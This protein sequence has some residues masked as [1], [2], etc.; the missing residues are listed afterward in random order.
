MSMTG[1][2]TCSCLVSAD[3]NFGKSRKSS[4][5]MILQYAA[6]HKAICCWHAQFTT[7]SQQTAAL[8]TAQPVFPGAAQCLLQGNR[9]EDPSQSAASFKQQLQQRYGDNCPEFRETSWQDAAAE[10]HQQYKFLLVYLHSPDHE[11]KL[12]FLL[13][14][15]INCPALHVYCFSLPLQEPVFLQSSC[16]VCIDMPVSVSVCA[17][18]CVCIG[19]SVRAFAILQ[20]HLSI[21]FLEGMTRIILLRLHASMLTGSELKSTALHTCAGHR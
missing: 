8:L 5:M 7:V 9:I 1:C 18:V 20:T 21:V 19:L 3:C 12:L 6:S 2:A 16:S 13:L 15:T 11:V 4:T 17:N 10:A 14:R